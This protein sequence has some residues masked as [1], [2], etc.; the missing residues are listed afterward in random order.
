ML[1]SH[2]GYLPQHHDRLLVRGGLVSFQQGGEQNR[3][4]GDDD[5]GDQ[6]AALVGDGDIEISGP[7]QRLLAADLRDGST[8]MV[9][10]LDPVL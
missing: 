5:G 7:D 4:V 6:A 2:W 8:L 1:P 3:I 9:V 10:G